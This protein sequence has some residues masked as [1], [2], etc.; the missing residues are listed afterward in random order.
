[1]GGTKIG[2]GFGAIAA[3]GGPL[4]LAMK[5]SDEISLQEGILGVEMPLL[6]D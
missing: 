6:C 4:R 5:G 3:Y 2:I 1:M